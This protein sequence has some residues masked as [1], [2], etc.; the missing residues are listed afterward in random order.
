MLQLY[1]PGGSTA[2]R[3]I[4]DCELTFPRLGEQRLRLRD[5]SML[6]ELN[7]SKLTRMRA[8]DSDLK[9]HRAEGVNWNEGAPEGVNQNEGLGVSTLGGYIQFSP[10]RHVQAIFKKL[11]SL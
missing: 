6:A 4:I 2:G 11:A 1:I 7:C 5:L 3:E 10:R 9:Q 8:S